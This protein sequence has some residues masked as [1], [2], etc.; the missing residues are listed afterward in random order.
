MS[1]LLI[2]F[3]KIIA[4]YFLIINS[5][6]ADNLQDNENITIQNGLDKII[7][8]FG[9]DINIG[10]V[11]QSMDD[12]K[13]LYH[14]NAS[15]VFMPASTLKVF[16]AVAALSYLTPQYRFTTQLLSTPSALLHP[17]TVNGDLYIKFTGH[18]TLTTN[19]L[20][21]L[22]AQ[23]TQAGI[24]TINGNLVIDDTALDHTNWA[25][26]WM[27]DEQSICYAAPATA[28]VVNHNCF[29]MN[30]IANKQINAPGIIQILPNDHNIVIQNHTITRS[31][32]FYECPLKLQAIGNNTYDL[33]GC[34]APNKPPL[35]LDAA[36]NDP[37]LAVTNNL[38]QMLKQNKIQLNGT[39]ISGKSPADF[40]LIAE[41]DSPPLA[42]L[43]T[44][45]LKKSDNLI[46]DVIFKTLGGL[47][48]HTQ[49]TWENGAAAVKAIL[50]PQTGIDFHKMHLV[51]GA[52]LSRYDLVSPLQF[53]QLLGYAYRD[54]PDNTILFQALPISGT[55]GTLR[56][57]LGG[58]LQGKIHAK[59]GTME[60]ASGLVGYIHTNNNKTLSFTILINGFVGKQ[61]A[62]HHLQDHICQYLA[63]QG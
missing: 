13:I 2:N 48:Y 11:V 21:N 46:A 5:V 24:H 20:N 23:L 12:G 43:I 52:G 34:Y 25:S 3:L 60:S 7:A 31:A 18:P 56:Y 54:L 29:G 4:V 53:A 6:F 9:Q 26:G 32:H 14:R 39:I 28:I 33:T 61:T 19:D 57:R 15:T 27:W 50:K 22:I 41:H 62:Y 49:G 35:F 37:L 16:T 59:T 8:N 63:Q 10:I 36:L 17:G 55:D 42:N 45:M 38:K 47:Y 51:D 30:L 1:K 58:P 40:K 44:T